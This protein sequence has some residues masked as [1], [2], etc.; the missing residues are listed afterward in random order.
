MTNF[1][2]YAEIQ[3]QIKELNDKAKE[4]QPILLQEIVESG[5]KNIKKEFG[6]FS[7]A[8]RKKY[9]YS[10][11]V[12]ELEIKLKETKKEEEGNQEPIVTQTLMFRNK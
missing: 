4:L 9:T 7:I 2:I 8:E 6:T 11:K 5:E 1:E 12:V 10:E 3:K